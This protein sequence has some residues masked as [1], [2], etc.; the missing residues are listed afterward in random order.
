MAL[1]EIRGLRT[2]YFTRR[3]IVKAVDGVDLTV[4]RGD[5]LGLVGESGCGK[6]TLGLSIMRLV[7]PPGRVVGG[8]IVFDGVKLLGLDEESMRRLG[9]GGSP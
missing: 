1:L 9:V 3:G 2:Y 7:P 5:V 4:E 6:T 8:E